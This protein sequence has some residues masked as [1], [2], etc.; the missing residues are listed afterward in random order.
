MNNIELIKITKSAEKH[1]EFLSKGF[2]GNENNAILLS[3]TKAG[4]SGYGYK[5]EHIN[6]AN[7]F[8][9]FVMVNDMK[10]C[11]D[12]ASILF[13]IGCIIDWEENG[14]NS[15]FTFKNPNAIGVCGCGESFAV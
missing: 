8:N 3:V 1:F 5:L 15:N 11:I 6:N 4:C 12:P 2:T 9:D 7:E 10:L 14:L 13:L